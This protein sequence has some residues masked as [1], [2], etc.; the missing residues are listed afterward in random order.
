M[1]SQQTHQNQND[2]QNDV[3]IS[4]ERVS[5]CPET[6]KYILGDDWRKPR[7]IVK[8]SIERLYDVKLTVII[9]P[10]RDFNPNDWT[11]KFYDD[12]Q[13]VVTGPTV[14]KTNGQYDS[15]NV[16][17]NIIREI[18][19]D[20]RKRH[21]EEVLGL[22]QGFESLIYQDYVESYKTDPESLHTF[23]KGFEEIIEFCEEDYDVKIELHNPNNSRRFDFTIQ[24]ECWENVQKSRWMIK[25]KEAGLRAVQKLYEEEELALAFAQ[26]FTD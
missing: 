13:L 4:K 14:T 2:I 11:G 7:S 12:P 18:D 25:L 21:K 20:I 6:V 26:S 9:D 15:W 3:R 24:G 10:I 16:V 22:Q 1:A 8:R 23:Q 19:I 5:V 17:P